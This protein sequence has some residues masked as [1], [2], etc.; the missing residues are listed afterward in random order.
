MLHIT[1]TQVPRENG[2]HSQDSVVAAATI[3]SGVAGA[4]SSRKAYTFGPHAV[5]PHLPRTSQIVWQNVRNAQL[6][7]KRISRHQCSLHALAYMAAYTN[8]ASPTPAARVGKGRDAETLHETL[9]A[10]PPRHLVA[11]GTPLPSVRPQA[12]PRQNATCE[13]HLLATSRVPHCNVPVLH[14]AVKMQRGRQL[15]LGACNSEPRLAE[16]K[17]N[18]VPSSLDKRLHHTVWQRHYCTC[19]A[20]KRTSF[21]HQNCR[22]TRSLS[23]SSGPAPCTVSHWEIKDAHAGITILEKLGQ[24]LQTDLFGCELALEAPQPLVHGS[25][26]AAAE[27]AGGAHIASH[28]AQR[29]RGEHNPVA[30]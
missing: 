5:M 17:S 21:K 13:H 29:L 20:Y 30:L 25:L 24:R 4:V 26:R 2:S 7:E 23:A 3:A 11:P 27:G 15:A 19:Q 1:S 16:V 12:A 14:D 6:L 22:N 9:P 18:A 28:C 8:N 10:H